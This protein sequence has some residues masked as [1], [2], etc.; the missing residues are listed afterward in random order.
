MVLVEKLLLESDR[1]STG[2]SQS[3][4]LLD[5]CALNKQTISGC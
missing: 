3:F 2:M 1:G 4:S 5:Y